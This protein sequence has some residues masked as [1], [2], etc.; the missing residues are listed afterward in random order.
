M[1][2]RIRKKIVVVGGGYIGVELVEAYLRQGREVTL[3]DSSD[4][5]LIKYF[6]KQYADRIGRI[7]QRS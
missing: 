7:F 2:P 3:I 1:L 4:Q 6:D 5:M